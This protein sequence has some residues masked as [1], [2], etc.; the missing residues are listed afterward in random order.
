MII[1]ITG[2]VNENK[3]RTQLVIAYWIYIASMV[4]F[5]ILHVI[6]W[7]YYCIGSGKDN[8]TPWT[9]A[10]AKVDDFLSD[11]QRQAVEDLINERIA[12]IQN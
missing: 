6:K 10:P 11:K 3:A 5:K 4:L 1:F 7:Y 12:A 2:F 8:F 9:M